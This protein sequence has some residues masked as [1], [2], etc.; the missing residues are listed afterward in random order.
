MG[1]SVTTPAVVTLA[2]LSTQPVSVNQTFPSGPAVMPHGVL[3]AVGMG[4]SVKAPDVATFATLFPLYSV[5]QRLPSG[6]AAISCGMLLAV[7]TWYSVVSPTAAR[8]SPL[9]RISP[10]AKLTT[11]AVATHAKGVHIC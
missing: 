8:A 11:P 6:P 7:G 4:Y 1:Y 9:E 5:N 2:T 3:L 10:A